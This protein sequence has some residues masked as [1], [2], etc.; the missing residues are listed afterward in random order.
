MLIDTLY[1][2]Y[3]GPASS[4][5]SCLMRP[6]E[7]DGLWWSWISSDNFTA[8]FIFLNTPGTAK[9]SN[10]RYIWWFQIQK[11]TAPN[12]TCTETNQMV[13][14]PYG[15]GSR[16]TGLDTGSDWWKINSNSVQVHTF[17]FEPMLCDWPRGHNRVYPKRYDKVLNIPVFWLDTVILPQT[18]R[19]N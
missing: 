1:L 16:N 18:W 11:C 7:L 13:R 19:V 15:I 2:L 6:W 17:P 5:R 3:A 9:S 10:I 12:D 8:E 14:Y 4:C